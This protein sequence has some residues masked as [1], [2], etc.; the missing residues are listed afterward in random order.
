ML[1]RGSI[2]AVVAVS[3]LMVLLQ[4]AHG[5][6]EDMG[7][8]P[9]PRD[10]EGTP[11]ELLDK[12]RVSP[13]DTAGGYD[14][15]KFGAGWSRTAGGCDV[16]S[17]VLVAESLIPAVVEPGCQVTAGEWVSLY[18]GAR[19]ISPADLQI[20]H[21]VPLAEAWDSGAAAWS[22]ELRDAFAVDGDRPDALVAVSASSNQAKS[23]R[24][25]AEWLPPATG[26]RCWYATAWVGVKAAWDLSVDEA[27]HQALAAALATCPPGG[28]TP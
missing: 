12:L 13:E 24:D 22:P 1:P 23:D 6:L 7:T 4:G 8:E 19:T 17:E 10:V 18:D 16:R 14:R 27:E 3:L 20:D 9:L 15:E 25:P 28:P 5:L 21:L 26:A 2:K 11:V